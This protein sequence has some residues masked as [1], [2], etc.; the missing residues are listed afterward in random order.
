M[1]FVTLP[2]GVR[3]Y[4]ETEGAGEPLL[5]L[6]GMASDHFGWGPDPAD[7]AHPGR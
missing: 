2:D 1:P 4:Y 3:M 7:F 6:M 5:L